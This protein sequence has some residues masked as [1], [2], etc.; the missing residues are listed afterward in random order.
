MKIIEFCGNP[1][2]GKTVLCKQVLERLRSEGK[3]AYDYN[4]LKEKNIFRNVRFIFFHRVFKVA[5]YLFFFGIRFHINKRA[6][7]YSVKCGVI[8][9]QVHRWEMDINIDYVLFDEGI[10]QY[11]TTLAHGFLIDES[12]KTALTLLDD[13]YLNKD[14]YVLNCIVRDD[15]NVERLRNRNRPKD[16]FVKYFDDELLNSLS[17]KRKNIDFVLSILKP[18][19][20]FNVNTEDK[21][22]ATS[23]ILR[24]IDGIGL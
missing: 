4:E 23:L 5:L 15:V 17:I 22:A 6:L 14:I 20:V 10:I 13:F 3:N 11:I 9:E 18:R 21:L 24:N 7:I 12:V 1:G 19:R 16:R 2:S 8:I